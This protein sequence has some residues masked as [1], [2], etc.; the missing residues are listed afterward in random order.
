MS[1]PSRTLFRSTRSSNASMSTR[2][3]T[4]WRSTRS[5]T[6]WMST[7]STTSSTSIALTT[8]GATSLTTDW[9]IAVAS[10]RRVSKK[11]ARRVPRFRVSRRGFDVHA[12]GAPRQPEVRVARAFGVGASTR[13]SGSYGAKRRR[14]ALDE[15]MR[16]VDRVGVEHHTD[17]E[18]ITVAERADVREASEPGPEGVALLDHW[19]RQCGDRCGTQ[20]TSWRRSRPS[21]PAREV[22]GRAPGS[23]ADRRPMPRRSQ[24]ARR[25]RVAPA[26]SRSATMPK[27][28]P[29]CSAD[30]GNS[31]RAGATQLPPMSPL[32]RC[33]VVGSASLSSK[34][35]SADMLVVQAEARAGACDEQ[36]V[37]AAALRSGGVSRRPGSRASRSGS[38][39]RPRAGSVRV[40]RP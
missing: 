26:P 28:G 22:P 32:P 39:T 10:S 18:S 30:V 3:M 31:T 19:R 6:D 9:R 36:V 12:A 5:S 17:V 13:C 33:C 7:R 4:D 2:S 37:P 15:R 27:W 38:S 14:Q 35:G 8:V 11:A 20:A 16:V 34:E 21:S 29:G 1:T 40:D 23:A 24:C 25:A